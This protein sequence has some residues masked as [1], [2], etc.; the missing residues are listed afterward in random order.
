MWCVCVSVSVSV[1]V[2]VCVCAGTCTHMCVC[3]CVCMHACVRACMCVYVCVHVFMCACAHTCVCAHAEQSG[4]SDLHNA[5]LNWVVYCCNFTCITLLP[6]HMTLYH[7][8]ILHIRNALIISTPTS[9]A[10][11][12]TLYLKPILNR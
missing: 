9:C 11:H 4:R 10:C 2:C 7:T 12:Y 1:C 5:L 6:S 3:V 8:G